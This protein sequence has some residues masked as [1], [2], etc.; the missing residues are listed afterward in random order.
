[1]KY[2]LLLPLI[3]LLASCTSEKSVREGAIIDAVRQKYASANDD[4]TIKVLE[5][6]E[7]GMI[8]VADSVRILNESFEAGRERELDYAQSVLATA[9]Q[10]AAV[11]GKNRYTSAEEK[12]SV[13]ASLE[14]Q[15]MRIDSLQNA[16]PVIPDKYSTS[17]PTTILTRII[18]AK[19]SIGDPTGNREMTEA[20]DFYLSTDLKTVYDMKKSK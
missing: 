3:C 13:A 10:M 12:S 9:E 11:V 2:C 14:K 15:R 8:S 1:M 16:Q 6:E 19:V 18:K 5:S 17:P 4:Y 20:Y 7:T